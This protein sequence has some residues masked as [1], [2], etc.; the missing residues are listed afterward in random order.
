MSTAGIHVASYDSRI[1]GN[2][3]SN[4]DRGIDVD[5]EDNVIVRNTA[6]S[7]TINYDILSGNAIGEILDV[8][9]GGTLNSSHGP[10]INLKIGN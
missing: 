10:W 9:N 7:N 5:G 4:N 3:V 2:N 6:S 8:T 1:E